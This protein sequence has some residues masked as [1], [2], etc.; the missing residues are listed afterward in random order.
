MLDLEENCGED[1]IFASY[2]EHARSICRTYHL[3][4]DSLSN[5]FKSHYD[6][7]DPIEGLTPVQRSQRKLDSILEAERNFP[8]YFSSTG[9]TLASRIQDV[10]ALSF[11]AVT[12]VH[13]RAILP[14]AA[15][16]APP[17]C[18]TINSLER[19]GVIPGVNIR[20]SDIYDG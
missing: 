14:D 2:M 3:D 11:G 13:T 15:A 9:A 17:V 7:Q 1:R 16:A 18:D 8:L 20:R 12:S 5:V 19:T 6:S 10:L 4:F